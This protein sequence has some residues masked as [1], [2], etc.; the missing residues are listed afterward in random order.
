MLRICMV[1]YHLG[2]IRVPDYV[3]Q[4]PQ[5]EQRELFKLAFRT[6]HYGVKGYMHIDAFNHKFAAVGGDGLGV[7]TIE[8]LKTKSGAKFSVSEIHISSEQVTVVGQI[9]T[10]IWPRTVHFLPQGQLVLVA[11]VATDITNATSHL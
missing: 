9:R 2:W 11:F 6:Y 8:M 4:T 3:A 10:A 7:W 5:R 1:L